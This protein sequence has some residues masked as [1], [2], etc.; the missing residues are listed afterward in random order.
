MEEATGT[1]RTMQS[2]GTVPGWRLFTG[3][4][5]F[6]PFRRA[7][8]GVV[9][10]SSVKGG[11][12]AEKGPEPRG[13]REW[14]RSA[15]GCQQEACGRPPSPCGPS[16]PST[17]LRR[18]CVSARWQRAMCQEIIAI[19]NSLGFILSFFFFSLSLGSVWALCFLLKKQ[20][21]LPLV[22]LF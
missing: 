9:L 8:W 4:A 14:E 6:S 7:G 19:K 20:T 16:P 17:K 22:T 12:W 18:A 2:A 13:G 10:Q 3:N 11:G 1:Q 15:L 21:K 5:E